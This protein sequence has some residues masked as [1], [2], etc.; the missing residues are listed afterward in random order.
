MVSVLWVRALRFLAPNKRV[1]MPKIACC[2]MAK[3]I[4]GKYYDDSIDFLNKEGIK[5]EDILPITYINSGA[6][7]KAKVGEMGGLV[8]TSSNAKT[9]IATAL[10][11]MKENK[12]EF[13]LIQGDFT[14]IQNFIFSKKSSAL[15][16]FS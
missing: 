7:V 6:D 5:K 16:P 8:C 1:L 13:S 9:I 14:S 15:Y 2:A 12:E 10:K 3:M 4:D 11:N